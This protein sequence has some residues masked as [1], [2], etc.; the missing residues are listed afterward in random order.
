VTPGQLVAWT[1]AVVIVSSLVTA[2]VV[3]IAIAQMR[4]LP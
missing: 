1:I 4:L 2:N 3:A